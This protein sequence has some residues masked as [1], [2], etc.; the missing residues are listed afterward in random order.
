MTLKFCSFP[1]GNVFLRGKLSVSTDVKRGE[2]SRDV[3][4]SK[5]KSLADD[6]VRYRTV[7][8]SVKLQQD[9][10][11]L[12]DWEKTWQM[13]FN[14]EKC[15]VMRITHS[16]NPTTYDYK[17]GTTSLQETTSHTYLGFDI[18]NDLRWNQYVNKI[19]SSANRSLGFL[20]RNISAC[21]K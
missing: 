13:E 3:K 14:A 2:L 16:K 1:L 15:Y 4:K 8:D 10:D 17:L 21:S 19:T 6:C 20:R 11:I 12:H 5:L 18:T 7:E 9:L